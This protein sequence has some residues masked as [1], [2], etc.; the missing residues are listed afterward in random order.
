MLLFPNVAII[1]LEFYWNSN[2]NFSIWQPSWGLFFEFKNICE[3][4]WLRESGMVISFFTMGT[5]KEGSSHMG[6]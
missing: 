3:F 6:Y 1:I 5:I 2:K 4:V